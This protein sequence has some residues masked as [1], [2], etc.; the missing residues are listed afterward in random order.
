MPDIHLR[1]T[2]WNVHLFAKS[3]NYLVQEGV[4]S[5]LGST[6]QVEFWLTQDNSPVYRARCSICPLS[7][8]M[9]WVFLN[10]RH[11]G[12][13]EIQIFPL[14]PFFSAVHGPLNF[15]ITFSPKA[16]KE[17]TI[18]AIKKS[19]SVLL[20]LFF[21]GAGF[22]ASAN[23]IGAETLKITVSNVV[24]KGEP[25]PVGDVQETGLVFLVR[26]GIF[27]LENGEFGSFRAIVTA[28]QIKGKPVSYLGFTVYVFGDGSIIV[29][30]FQTGSAWP[31][32]E[33]KVAALRK[34]SGEMTY[35]SGRFKGIKGTQTMT[36]KILKAQK[37][38]ASGKAYNEFILTYT[39][40][41]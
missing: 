34:A 13:K 22:L 28:Q 27:A 11:E 19:L 33:G 21:V 30:S 4:F 26:D 2:G 15:I 10:G 29:A 32:P 40:S 39:L 14:E 7:G 35:G 41:P 18:M 6:C 37:G 1:I 38:E 8:F 5:Y 24:T 17:D 12:S 16:N 20:S 36:G 9:K 23:E 31:D 3:V 25:F